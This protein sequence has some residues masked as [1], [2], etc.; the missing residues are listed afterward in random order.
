MVELTPAE[1][2]KLP[3]LHELEMDGKTYRIR[4]YRRRGE[5]SG[6]VCQYLYKGVWRRVRNAEIISRLKAKAEGRE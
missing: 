3:L 6:T 5:F 2:A 4:G 1:M